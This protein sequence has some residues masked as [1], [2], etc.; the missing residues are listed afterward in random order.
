MIPHVGLT[1][2]HIRVDNLASLYFFHNFASPSDLSLLAI[3]W[4]LWAQ[5]AVVAYAATE[6]ASHHVA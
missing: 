2:L 1:T 4:I 5:F 6:A 3:E